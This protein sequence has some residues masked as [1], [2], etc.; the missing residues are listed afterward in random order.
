[1]RWVRGYSMKDNLLVPPVHPLPPRHAMISSPLSL[2][3]LTLCPPQWSQH[4]L[5]HD[6]PT[7]ASSSHCARALPGSTLAGARRVSWKERGGPF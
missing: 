5:M 2:C 6:C 4:H 1:M 3:K 7:N